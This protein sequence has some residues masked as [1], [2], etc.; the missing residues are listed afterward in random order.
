MESTI[1]N[2]QLNLLAL[3]LFVFI[4]SIHFNAFATSKDFYLER[5]LSVDTNEKTQWLRPIQL[6]NKNQNIFLISSTDGQFLVNDGD[7]SKKLSSLSNQK[8]FSSNAF[9]ALSAITL[10]PNFTLKDQPGYATLYT[11]HQEKYNAKIKQRLPSNTTQNSFTFDLVINEWQVTSTNTLT[12]TENSQREIL[13]IGTRSKLG[14]IK[15]LAFDPYKKMWEEDHGLLYILLNQDVESPTSAMQSGVLLRIKPVKFGVKQYSAPQSNPYTKTPKI[16]NEIYALGLQ[17]SEQLLWTKKDNKFIHLLHQ[18]NDDKLISKIAIGSDWREK[19]TSQTIVSKDNSIKSNVAYYHGRAIPKIAGT[20]LHIDMQ[21]NTLQLKQLTLIS[22]SSAPISIEIENTE[23][24]SQDAEIFIGNNDELLLF[25]RQKA[26][27]YKVSKTLPSIINKEESTTVIEN[28]QS[29][30]WTSTALISLALLCVFLIIAYVAWKKI[31]QKIPRKILHQRFARFDIN[32]DEKSISLFRR[33]ETDISKTITLSDISKSE[34]L[35]NDKTINSISLAADH[36]FNSD[37]ESNLRGIFAKEKRDKMVDDKVRQIDL[38]LTSNK[39]NATYICLYL[40]KGNQRLT[41]ACYSETIE[42]LIHWNWIIS[43]VINPLNTSLP[44]PK[45]IVDDNTS[46]CT[47]KAQDIKQPQAIESTPNI[48]EHLDSNNYSD[49]ISNNCDK[50]PITAESFEK[51]EFSE[52]LPDKT[53]EKNDSNED[54]AL[55]AS[56]DKLARL[57]QSGFLSEQEFDAAKAKLLKDLIKN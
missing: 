25:D 53:T 17:G 49:N 18:H 36:G 24:I 28:H 22:N 31:K 55:I 9:I 40:R 48:T 14:Q 13:R 42:Q 10:H 52:Q 43:K 1:K 27:L 19:K 56:L 35:L 20:P 32:D 57:K 15:Q 37:I 44:V 45:K 34:I 21:N 30:N 3:A 38:L 50:T 12:L 23:N 29:Q 8:S 6:P 47:D 33:H 51:T 26:T 54:I 41:K 5:V 39:D 16:N 11:A 46:S 4:S 7:Q 2:R